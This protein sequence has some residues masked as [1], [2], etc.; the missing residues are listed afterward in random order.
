MSDPHDPFADATRPRAPKIEGLR[1]PQRAHG[2]RLAMIHAMHLRQLSSVRDVM[3]RVAA[4]ESASAMLGEAV[5]S[6]GMTR[7]YRH[8]GTLCGQECAVLTSRHTI[9]D[10]SI[11]P[12]LSERGEGLQSVIERLIVEHGVIHELLEQLEATAMQLVKRSN[13]E[14]FARVRED[15]ARVDSAVR[16]HFGYEQEVLED[17]LG[18]WNIAI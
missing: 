3:E 18:Y 6:L 9:E 8:F 4:G 14:A 11:F 15:F 10:Q 1:P 13:G 5:S 12:A 2:Q 16:S 17:A 7:N